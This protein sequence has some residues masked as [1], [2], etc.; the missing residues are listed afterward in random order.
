M[1]A[2]IDAGDFT[3]MWVS[4][5]ISISMRANGLR[6]L[7]NILA[8]NAGYSHPDRMRASG[9]CFTQATNVAPMAWLK[10]Q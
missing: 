9:P 3:S 6:G 7:S 1:D 5:N 4:H 10:H 8:F 2:G